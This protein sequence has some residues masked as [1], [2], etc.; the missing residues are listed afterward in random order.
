MPSINMIAP[1]R[2]EKMRLE[3]DMRRL[4]VV[5]LAELVFA[6]GL[7]GWVCTKLLTT[8]SRISDLQVQL[9]SLQPIVRQIEG[10]DS[11]TKKLL[12]KLDL[13]NKAKDQTMTWYS[14]LDRLTQSFPQSTYL[15]RVSTRMSNQKDAGTV[16]TLNGVSTSQTKIGETMMRLHEVPEFERVDLHF[17]DKTIV[18]KADVLEFEIGASMKGQEPPKGAKPNAGS[19]S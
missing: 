15:T 6:V 18:E 1:R 8:H 13:L 11:A 17:T 2:A 7:G 4:V 19:Q 5:I 14:V 16:L 12:P 10:Y 9:T 3:R